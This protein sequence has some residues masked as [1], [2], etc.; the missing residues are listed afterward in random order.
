[1]TRR[2][3]HTHRERGVAAVEMALL[4]PLLILLLMGGVETAWLLGQALDVRNA[5][6]EGGRLAAIDYGDTATI[7]SE[8]CMVMDNDDLTSVGFSGDAAALGADIQVTVTKT[9]SLL[10]NF[11]SW[12]FPPTMTLSSTAVFALEVSPPTWTDGTYACP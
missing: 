2:K 1:M 5:A 8:V 12:A 10:T 3:H 7:G 4:A 9:P 11:L 6:R